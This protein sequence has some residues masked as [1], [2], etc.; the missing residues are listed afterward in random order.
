MTIKTERFQ[1]RIP[2]KGKKAWIIHSEH[3]LES[4]ARKKVETV[5]C[6]CPSAFIWDRQTRQRRA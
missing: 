3:Q 4:D 5:K 6:M 2:T 1:V